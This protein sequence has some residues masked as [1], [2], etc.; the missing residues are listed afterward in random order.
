MCDPENRKCFTGLLCEKNID[1]CVPEPCHHGVCKDGIATFSCECHPGYTGSICNIQV[2][3]CHS[4]PCQNR[5]RTCVDKVNSFLYTCKCDPGWVGQ[6]CEQE[7]DE[8]QSS[9]CQN[10][11]SCV[12]RHNG[13]TCQCRPGFTGILIFSTEH[14]LFHNPVTSYLTNT[15]SVLRCELERE[16]EGERERENLL[17]SKEVFFPLLG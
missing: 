14:V 3:E 2:Q 16:R 10:G 9:P 6:L 13:Y 5:G 8:C 11:G 12:D 7:K 15:C 17:N 4:N 1:D